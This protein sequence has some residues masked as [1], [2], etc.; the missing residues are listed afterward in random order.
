[1]DKKYLDKAALDKLIVSIKGRAAT[2][3]KDVHKAA[4]SALH[5]LAEHGDIGFANRLQLALGKGQRKTALAKWFITYGK[6]AVNV[7]KAS[8]KDQ[9]FV[10]SKAG[11]NDLEGGDAQPWYD[12][13]TEPELPEIFDIKAALAAL[14]KKA[15]KS[16]NVNDPT[17][18]DALASLVKP[19]EA[20]A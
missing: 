2:L 3:D 11:V 13:K 10:F 6:L 12:I 5:H 16:P 1:V 8:M 15:A 17:L 7:D 4:M 19:A 20:K 18:R 14:L 9:P